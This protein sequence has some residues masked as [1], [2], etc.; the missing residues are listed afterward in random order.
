MRIHLHILLVLLTP[1]AQPAFASQVTWALHSEPRTL[2]PVL[3]EDG[4][5]EAVRYLTQGALLRMNRKTQALEP[6]LATSWKV[7]PDGR[8][9]RFKLRKDVHFS[10][11]APFSASDVVWSMERLM[12]PAVHAPVAATFET[13]PGSVSHVQPDPYTVSF[14]FPGRVTGLAEAFDSVPIQKAGSHPAPGGPTLGP[15][16]LVQYERGSFLL[17]R[18]NPR[19]WKRDSAGRHLPYIDE[20]R[21]VIQQNRALELSQYL[22]GDLQLINDVSPE[23]L[24]VLSAH[25]QSGVLDLGP[26][27]DSEQMWFNQV[28]TS[29]LPEYK[30]AWFQS[31]QFRKAISN[32]INRKD[33]VRLALEG[34]GTPASGPISP[35]NQ[36]WFDARLQPLPFSDADALQLLATAGFRKKG[37]TLFDSQGH[38]VEFSLI[39]NAGNPV[40]E[41]MATL[42]QQDLGR[43]GITVR[44]VT[45]DFPALIQRITQSFDYDACLLGLV[46]V[47]PDPNA[48]MNVWLS[49]SPNHQWNPE[50]RTPA[51]PWE[52]EIDALMKQ[53]AGTSDLHQRKLAI[54][55]FQQ[56]VREQEPFIYLVNRD[57]V[58]AV[59]PRLANAQPGI[60]FP[61]TFWRAEWM[62]VQPR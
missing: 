41:T 38:A 14:T 9:I 26:S 62:Q 57:A 27:L 13:A 33:L 34:H 1:F 29:P 24:R 22:R 58:V 48:Q 54:D 47:D 12:D 18:R 30:R 2:D 39:T 17:F 11:G 19:Y 37:D 43:I 6:E 56:I 40:R 28:S 4:S 7:S 46:N 44:L 42:I 45:L 16:E 8:S 15:Y 32:A 3:V 35:A 20:V 31:T 59:S 21:L 49:S 25:P 52:A 55:K 23:Q 51:T 5:S 53:Q 10:D 60:L 50:E 61:Q 36:T